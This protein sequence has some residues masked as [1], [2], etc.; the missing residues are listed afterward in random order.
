MTDNFQ[1]H[2]IDRVKGLQLKYRDE[3]GDI[4]WNFMV[5]DDGFIYEGRG[6]R[7]QGELP[8]SHTSSFG[9]IGMIIAFIGIFYDRQP[10]KRQLETFDIFLRQQI[11]R[12]MIRKDY[13]LFSEDQLTF[14]KPVAEGIIEAIADREEYYERKQTFLE[15]AN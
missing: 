6:F 13:K 7:H 14:S 11:G 5:G 12:D 10:S 3:L 1:S 2:C 8:G 9:E 15:R 4:P